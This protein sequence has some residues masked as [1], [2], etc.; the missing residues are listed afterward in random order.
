MKRFLLTLA[1]LAAFWSATVAYAVIIIRGPVLSPAGYT[2]PGTTIAW[3][4]ADAIVGLSN[5]DPVSTWEDSQNAND[6]TASGSLRPLYKTNLQ[7]SL[8]GVR[9]DGT[10]DYLISSAFGSAETQ[11]NT[12]YIVAT[13]RNG[14]VTHYLFD[15]GGSTRHMIYWEQGS[16]AF[17]AYA[18]SFTSGTSHTAGSVFQLTVEFNGSSSQIWLNGTG[19]GTSDAGSHDLG[20][21]VLGAATGGGAVGAVD[22]F[23]VLVDA[24]TR[25]SAVETYLKNKWGTP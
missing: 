21:I 6:V 13:I 14:S 11:P 25:D 10:D 2:P 19:S 4:K 17:K 7:N 3:F 1:A 15:G 23:E 8:P 12:V 5:D 22:I 24:A 16:T 20:E 9:F 18:G